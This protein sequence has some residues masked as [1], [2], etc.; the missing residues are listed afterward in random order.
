MHLPFA[1]ALLESAAAF[2]QSSLTQMLLGGGPLMVPIGFASVVALAYIVERGSNLRRSQ[3]GTPR[4]GREIVESVRSGGAAEGLAH[5]ERRS[6]PLTRILAASLARC[7]DSR[8]A[9]ERAAQEAGQREI[10]RIAAGLRPLVVVAMIAPLLGL[11]G[12]VWGMIQAFASIG[13]QGALGRPELLAASISQALVTTAAGLAI[14]IPSQAAYYFF[15]SRIEGF[16]RLAEDVQQK[17]LLALERSE[18]SAA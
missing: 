1:L 17:V 4:L 15:K 3:L 11:L 12:T 6:L 9:M 10:A 13:Q 16:A 5:C 7:A 14:A 8:D 18:R 2:Q